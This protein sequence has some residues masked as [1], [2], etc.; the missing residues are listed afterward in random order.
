MDKQILPWSSS[1]RKL[2][3]KKKNIMFGSVRGYT[4]AAIS[5]DSNIYKFQWQIFIDTYCRY[6]Y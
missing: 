6:E 2:V 4:N 5:V 3:G 1:L